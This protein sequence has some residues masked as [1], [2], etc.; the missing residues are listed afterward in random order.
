MSSHFNGFTDES[1][2]DFIKRFE[3]F[4]DCVIATAWV[5]AVGLT[6]FGV[7]LSKE[8]QT[9]TQKRA[10]LDLAYRKGRQDEREHWVKTEEGE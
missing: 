10:E 6:K 4:P 1:R 9:V 7:D 3:G 2:K 5:Y 8:W